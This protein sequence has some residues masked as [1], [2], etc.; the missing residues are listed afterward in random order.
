LP[1]LSD[2]QVIIRTGYPWQAPQIV[3]NQVTYPIASAML[4][5]WRAR[6]AGL[7]VHWRQFRLRTV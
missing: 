4:G 2:V 5:S 3:E 7:F 1:D 6:G